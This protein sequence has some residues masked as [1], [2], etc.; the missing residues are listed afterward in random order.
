MSDTAANTQRS[1][2]IR[3]GIIGGAILLVVILVI[4]TFSSFN[5]TRNDGITYEQGLMSQYKVNKDELSTYIVSFNESLGVADRST[6]KLDKILSDAVQGRYD[7]ADGTLTPGTGGAM[8]SAIAESYPD[9]TANAETYA[10][11]QDLVISGRT[12]YKNQQN[13]L[14]DMVR[15][16]K[17]WSKK[18]LVHSQMVKAIGFPSN[19]LEITDGTNTYH[20]IDALD[21]IDR[22]IIVK[23][24]ADAYDS[25][26]IAPLI[27]PESDDTK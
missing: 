12:A 13:K 4:S 9:L 5:N 2:Y 22:V 10:K 6:S 8:F 27:K 18:G 14:I 3:W 20:G 1:K 16:Y 23:E 17:V 25:G 15:E 24:A 11:V 21:R 26:T 19:D 7:N